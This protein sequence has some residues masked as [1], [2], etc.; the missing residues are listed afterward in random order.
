MSVLRRTPDGKQQVVIRVD[1][2]RA[3]RDPRENILVKDGD[4]LVLRETPQEALARYI[5][6]QFRFTT[7]FLSWG[8]TTGVASLP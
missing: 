2:N 7:R 8:N 3:M 4:V 1:L 6:Q 5:S